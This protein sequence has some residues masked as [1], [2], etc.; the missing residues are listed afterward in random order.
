MF[1]TGLAQPGRQAFEAPLA[2]LSFT[3]MHDLRHRLVRSLVSVRFPCVV[4]AIF[5]ILNLEKNGERVSTSLRGLNSRPGDVWATLVKT[6]TPYFFRR[7][8]V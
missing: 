4:L 3:P 2:A 8:R 7:Y 1:T 5:E 6:S